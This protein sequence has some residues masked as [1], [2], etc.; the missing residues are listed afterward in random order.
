MRFSAV[1]TLS[2][3]SCRTRTPIV[4]HIP[5]GW[6]GNSAGTSRKAVC[7]SFCVTPGNVVPR[8]PPGITGRSYR[9]ELRQLA[10]ALNQSNR[11]FPAVAAIRLLI[12]LWIR[13][14]K[15]DE[16]MI[17][18]VETRVNT[19][20][21]S[22]TQTF[23][24]VLVHFN[25]LVDAN[26][27]V[28]IF[29]D[30]RVMNQRNGHRNH[31]LRSG[32]PTAVAVAAPAIPTA[33]PGIT[34]NDLYNSLIAVPARFPTPLEELGPEN[35]QI[36]LDQGDSTSTSEIPLDPSAHDRSSTRAIQ[37][38]QARYPWILQ[39]KIDALLRECNY[40]DNHP[41]V[42]ETCNKWMEFHE[43]TFRK[44]QYRE[45]H[46]GLARLPKHMQAETGLPP[47]GSVMRTTW[48]FPSYFVTRTTRDSAMV[49]PRGA[50]NMYGVNVRVP[51]ICD[52]SRNPAGLNTWS[53]WSQEELDMIGSMLS[54]IVLQVIDDDGDFARGAT[55][56]VSHF[57]IDAVYD[58]AAAAGTAPVVPPAPSL[59]VSP[60]TGQAFSTVSE[61]NQQRQGFRVVSRR[62]RAGPG[63]GRNLHTPLGPAFYREPAAMD[64][65]V[66]CKVCPVGTSL[67]QWMFADWD[68]RATV[69][70]ARDVVNAAHERLSLWT[71]QPFSTLSQE[72]QQRQGFRVL[73]RRSRAGTGVSR[74]LHPPLGPAYYREPESLRDSGCPRTGRK[75]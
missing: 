34:A 50:R 6:S 39:R 41:R 17:Q 52:G 20:F 27:L 74:N 31:G 16:G 49:D 61:E 66:S 44:Q 51:R 11:A 37:R 36:A 30:H 71:G 19:S 7:S 69:R 10:P 15:L 4:I 56:L 25:N 29:A 63:D 57:T 65:L 42:R 23:H 60:W 47:D 43:D 58:A 54:D 72:N 14:G 40:N 45:K 55:R 28:A 24:R 73:V 3:P 75:F 62:S 35:A 5:D 68:R 2:G 1:R 9:Q 22:A 21:T 59:V 13:E 33:F 53:V 12:T 8:Y 18:A 64:F 48:E 32:S 46:E 67:A 38:V 70:W 26:A